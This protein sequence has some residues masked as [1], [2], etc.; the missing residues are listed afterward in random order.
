MAPGDLWPELSLK[1]NEATLGTSGNVSKTCTWQT[2][3]LASV[4]G[5]DRPGVPAA[6]IGE[7]L[8]WPGPESYSGAPPPAERTSRYI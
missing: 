6:C 7:Q 3:A 8:Q 1:T 4:P 2:K 5:S